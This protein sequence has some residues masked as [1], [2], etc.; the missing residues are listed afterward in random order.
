LPSEVS[1]FFYKEWIV[2]QK[3]KKKKKGRNAYQEF[4]FFNKINKRKV[5]QYHGHEKLQE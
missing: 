4:N 2:A 3:Q 5:S 1:C